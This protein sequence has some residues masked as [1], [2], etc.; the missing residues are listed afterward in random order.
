M[1]KVDTISYFTNS[2]PEADP[3]GVLGIE[4]PSP[5]W[6]ILSILFNIAQNWTTMSLILPRTPPFSGNPFQFFT[7]SGSAPAVILM[8]LLL[9]W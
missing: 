7:I 6:N 8:D 4:T 9:P 3:D 2:C 1:S 5:F